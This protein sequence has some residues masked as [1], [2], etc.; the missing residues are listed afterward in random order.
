MFEHLPTALTALQTAL[1]IG[2]AAIEIKG[3][4]NSQDQ[5][6]E[7]NNAIIS[8]QQMIIQAQREQTSILAELEEIKKQNAALLAWNV[9]QAHYTRTEIGHGVFAYILNGYEGEQ[10]HAHKYCCTCFE[11]S[12]ESTLQQFQIEVGRKI[13]LKCPSGCPDISFNAYMDMY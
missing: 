11:Q 13:G 12:K 6:M 4:I 5:L 9:E 8:A 3:G 2:K 10:Q 7:F 1:S